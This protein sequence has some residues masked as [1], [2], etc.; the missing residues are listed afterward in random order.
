M[1]SVNIYMLSWKEGVMSLLAPT[2]AGLPSLGTVD[3]LGQVILCCG[4]VPCL[5]GNLVSLASAH[6]MTVASPPL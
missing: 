6:L 1:R 3:V 4:A 2:T 5:V